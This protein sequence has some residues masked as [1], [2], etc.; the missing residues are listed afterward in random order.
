MDNEI[1]NA[2]EA[3]T[4]PWKD[5]QVAFKDEILTGY[6]DFKSKLDTELKQNAEGFVRIGYLLKVARDTN[7]L[8]ES[9][10]KNVAEFAQAEYGLS[11][12]IVSR[13]I[14]I[15]DKYA[16][17][18]YSDKLQTQFEG[19]G[20]AKLQDMLTLPDSI[21]EEIEP[22][23]TRREIAEIKKQ[24]AAEE[25][26][27]PLE[28]ALEAASPEVQAEEKELTLTQR[29][30]KDVIKSN[31]D[32]FSPEG[33]ALKDVIEAN[34]P[35]VTDESF[36]KPYEEKLLDLL[37][38]NGTATLWA[39]VP[40]AGR[41]MVTI[42]GKDEPINMTNARDGSKVNTSL[43]DACRDIA[44]LFNNQCTFESWEKLYGEKYPDDIPDEPKPVKESEKPVEEKAA[45]EPKKEEPK[46][47]NTDEE[48]KDGKARGNGDNQRGSRESDD[49]NAGAGR[50]GSKEEGEVTNS[51]SAKESGK[52]GNGRD[53]GTGEA[54]QETEKDTG[55]DDI[56]D[57]AV[58][59]EETEKGEKDVQEASA[60]ANEVDIRT[61]DG[62]GEN[63][64]GEN[65]PEK[66]KVAPVQPKQLGNLDI[67]DRVV[68]V[69]TGETGTMLGH[70]AG[71]Y[72]IGIDNGGITLVSKD[73]TRWAKAEEKKEAEPEPEAEAPEQEEQKQTFDFEK[74]HETML[75][76]IEALD[77]MFER[78]YK[79]EM[80]KKEDLW[81]LMEKANKLISDA[82]IPLKVKAEDGGLK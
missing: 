31:V 18:G 22:T 61:D 1:L 33:G 45:E 7:I 73:S 34:Y 51:V 82:G 10:Y 47:D 71:E 46:A 12:D 78:N 28:V 35:F 16:I 56:R 27:T 52:Q 24:V 62:Y 2:A 38:P 68:N 40:G 58:S 8:A 17:N 39:R 63:N 49:G 53:A 43:A 41:Y 23:L 60:Q 77:T 13:Y 66:E 81:E 72:K 65:V 75:A 69:E 74:W 42:K 50:K 32:I 9:G 15:N 54:I 57:G 44:E 79:A 26:I 11:K 25:K 55:A 48:K 37:A 20:V 59:E 36:S 70:C 3:G 19:F 6:N 30:W 21:I 14:A 67:G 29:V 76:D 64:V 80:W 5:D 4:E